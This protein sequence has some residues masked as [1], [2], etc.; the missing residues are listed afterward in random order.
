[1]IIGF[2]ENLC[3]SLREE[4]KNSYH[5]GYNDGHRVIT[6]VTLSH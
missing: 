5:P 6:R 2:R 4:I 1:M 3:I